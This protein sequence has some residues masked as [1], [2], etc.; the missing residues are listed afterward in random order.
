MYGGGVGSR[1]WDG[2][3]ASGSGFVDDASIDI[4]R[5]MRV[6]DRVAVNLVAI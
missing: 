2:E 5:S 6:V 3:V 4:A 1:G